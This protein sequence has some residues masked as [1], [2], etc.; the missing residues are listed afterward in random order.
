MLTPLISLPLTRWLPDLQFLAGPGFFIGVALVTA[1]LFLFSLITWRG[2]QARRASSEISA[3]PAPCAP[4]V[5][6]GL[7]WSPEQRLSRPSWL[8]G[9][10]AHGPPRY[11]R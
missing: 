1:P 9:A 8:A 10:A 11:H 3:E 2:P 5:R 4:N 6:S 7:T